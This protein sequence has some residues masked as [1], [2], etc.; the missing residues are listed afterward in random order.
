MLVRG[1][2]VVYR[3]DGGTSLPL[4]LTARAER[5]HSFFVNMIAAYLYVYVYVYATWL[6]N[7]S[8]DLYAFSIPSFGAEVLL[9]KDSR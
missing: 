9:D 1:P 3:F 6:L 5:S 8:L 7:R 2:V 4:S